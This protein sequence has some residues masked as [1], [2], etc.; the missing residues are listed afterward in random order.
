MLMSEFVAS[1]M[2]PLQVTGLGYQTGG[3]RLLEGVSLT[4]QPG[5]LCVIMGANGAGK[6]VLLRLLHGL[7]GHQHEGSVAWNGELAGE[8]VFKQQAMVFQKPVLLRR[9]VAANLDFALRLHGDADRAALRRRR[10]ELLETVGLLPRADQPARLLSG[11]EQ[12]RL[13]LARACACE[14]RVLFLDEPTAS[15]DP[16]SVQIIE[17]IVLERHR[18]G[19]AI[20]FVTHDIGQARRLADDIVFLHQGRLAEFTPAEQFFDSPASEAGRAYLAGRLM[21]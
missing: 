1:P 13:A 19:C 3:K 9:S 14:P 8:S 2:L 5:R 7:L 18:K 15:L 12:Q 11:G 10:N 17:Q 6:S 20:L 4:I 21:V 16:A